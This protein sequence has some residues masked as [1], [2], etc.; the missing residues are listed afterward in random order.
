MDHRRLQRGWFTDRMPRHIFFTIVW[1]TLFFTKKPVFQLFASKN[2][3]K[4]TFRITGELHLQ[5]EAEQIFGEAFIWKRW[6]D[7][8][9]YNPFP[10]VGPLA[11]GLMKPQINNHPFSISVCYILS[12]L[13]TCI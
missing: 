3:L 11:G 8:G 6:I 13:Q 7:S 2:R 10:L 9:V 5:K 12:L 4:S 1:D